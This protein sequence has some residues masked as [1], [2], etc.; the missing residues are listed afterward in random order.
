MNEQQPK[1]SRPVVRALIKK[2]TPESQKDKD[3][4][5]L[6][7]KGELHI[8]FK[9]NDEPKSELLFECATDS[10]E[11]AAALVAAFIQKGKA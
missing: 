4:A 1:V 2:F 6:R 7:H 8:T 9:V 3:Q 5:D 10:E 11:A